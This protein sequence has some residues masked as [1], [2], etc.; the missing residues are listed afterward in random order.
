MRQAKMHPQ[1][2]KSPVIPII[3]GGIAGGA[4]S[5]V[6]YRTCWENTTGLPRGSLEPIGVVLVV[7]T[8]AV[9]GALGGSVERV[10]RDLWARIARA[11]QAWI[12][13]LVILV[14][15]FN[16]FQRGHFVGHHYYFMCGSF[17][18]GFAIKPL[19]YFFT[20][21]EE[22]GGGMMKDQ[23]SQRT[24]EDQAT[25]EL[26]SSEAFLNPRRVLILLLVLALF[27]LSRVM[28]ARHREAERQLALKREAWK[29]AV[30]RQR[31]VAELA[32]KRSSD[33]MEKYTEAFKS[34]GKAWEQVKT[35]DGQT[36]ARPHRDAMQRLNQAR[37]EA[38][39]A[40]EL[41]RAEEERLRQLESQRPVR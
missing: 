29:Q 13:L 12:V 6:F 9:F 32:V 26:V 37:D 34:L 35:A 22:R 28:E 41:R 23:D 10:P 40:L 5:G 8:G 18:I 15:E 33:S 38:R 2:D 21:P 24:G 3:L 4:G 39:R 31:S 17:L 19:Y 7:L 25:A 36:F 14:I 20:L 11:W 16:S 30:E 27:G 1:R